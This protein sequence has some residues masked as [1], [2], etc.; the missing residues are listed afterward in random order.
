MSEEE[1][2]REEQP[3]M[4]SR[5]P[6]LASDEAYFVAS[7]NLVQASHLND[8]SVKNNEDLNVDSIETSQGMTPMA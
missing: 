7:Q 8:K 3:Y 4:E 5:L 1:L 6:R 2:P